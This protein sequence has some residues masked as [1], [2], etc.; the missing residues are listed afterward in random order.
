MLISSQS[1]QS[2]TVQHIR[3]HHIRMINPF[4]NKSFEIDAL[5]WTNWTKK[6]ERNGIEKNSSLSSIAL[7]HMILDRWIL[8]SVLDSRIRDIPFQIVF[9]L[10]F[11]FYVPFSSSL[12]KN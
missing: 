8:E 6:E 2:S 12:E 5:N 1:N 9:L 3:S 10:L 7:I 4:W 11:L